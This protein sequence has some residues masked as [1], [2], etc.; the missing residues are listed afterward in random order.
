MMKL[1]E[2]I[3]ALIPMPPNHG[4]VTPLSRSPS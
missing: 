2:K 3:A 4:P 1:I